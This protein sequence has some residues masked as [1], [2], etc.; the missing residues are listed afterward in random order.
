MTLTPDELDRL[1]HLSEAPD[2]P[3]VSAPLVAP[4]G[5]SRKTIA[6]IVGLL[7]ILAAFLHTQL[8]ISL[9]AG[10]AM[11]GLAPVLAFIFSEAKNDLQ[12]IKSGLIQSRKYSDPAFL[13]ALAGS[14]LPYINSAL[15]LH[16][17]AETILAVLAAVI[18]GVA[19]KRNA[20]L[21]KA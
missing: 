5:P 16:L 6:F 9:Q 21:K 11:A 2:A 13:A 3:A 12:K 18:G 7:G 15:G 8:G 17:P 19:V 10:E 4:A 14:V 20:D 1:K